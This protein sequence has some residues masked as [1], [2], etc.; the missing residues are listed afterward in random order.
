MR[1]VLLEYFDR[2]GCAVEERGRRVKGL[3][4]RVRQLCVY[5]Y[6]HF[7]ICVFSWFLIGTRQIPR[8]AFCKL[9]CLQGNASVHDGFDLDTGFTPRHHLRRCNSIREPSFPGRHSFKQSSFP[10]C[11]PQ[12]ISPVILDCN[13]PSSYS[14]IRSPEVNVEGWVI[15][16]LSKSTSVDNALVQE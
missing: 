10:E 5:L 1:S 8:S 14:S 16:M 2:V 11:H 3:K 7:A 6:L 13:M 12:L 9:A 15:V 4:T